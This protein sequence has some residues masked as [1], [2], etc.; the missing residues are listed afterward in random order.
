[1]DDLAHIC[2]EGPWAIDKA[3]LVLERWR[4]NLVIGNLQPNFISIWVQIHGLPLEY[5]Y[6]ELAKRT[7]Q[8]MGIVEKV[9]WEDRIPRNVRFMRV[10]VRIDPWVPMIA[11]FMLRLDDGARVWLQCR[12]ERVHKLCTRC[13][14]IGHTRG[15]CT[16]SMDEVEVMLF[17]QRHRIQ[18]LHQV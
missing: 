2:S 11:G 8:L 14:L 15:Q 7:G 17:K 5:Q 4:P 10:K 16:Y 18:E 12:Y 1:M 9:D 13:G 3:L 6:P